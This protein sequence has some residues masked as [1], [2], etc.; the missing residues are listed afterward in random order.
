LRSVKAIA[1][2]YGGHISI[3]RTESVFTIY[4]MVNA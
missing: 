4:V 2:R 1:E 3:E